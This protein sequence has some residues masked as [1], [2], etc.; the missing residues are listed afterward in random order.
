MENTE[1][2][3]RKIKLTDIVACTAIAIM[4]A[5]YYLPYCKCQVTNVECLVSQLEI[6]A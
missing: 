1:Q 2:V 5:L 3:D 6:Q 4:S